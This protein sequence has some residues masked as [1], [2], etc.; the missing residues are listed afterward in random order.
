[1]NTNST[2]SKT[3]STETTTKTN[4]GYETPV[5]KVEET[6]DDF[7]YDIEKKVEEK[8]DETKKPEPEKKVEDEKAK[9]PSTGYS[10]V[11]ES[12]KNKDEK[13]PDEAKAPE[14]KSADEKLVE[15]LKESVKDLPEEIN[16][17]KV[18][19]FIQD[20]KMTKEQAKAYSELV[21]AEIAESKANREAF[22]KQQK[23]D[24]VKELKNDPEFGG[25]NF[26][27][28]VDRVEKV[29]ENNMP[30]LKKHLTERSGMLPPYIMKD[31]LA[32]SKALNPV[33]DFVK[34]DAGEVTESGNN[35][36]DDLYK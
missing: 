29:L 30:N 32:I 24:F 4:T 1:M 12:D 19:K 25:E 35:F 16:K 3:D 31:L 13:K 5:E 6:V 34:G 14:E 17:D 20:N 27:R 18:L 7:G 28:N 9:N 2:G 15:E 21:K 23:A 8:T 36:L 33:T 22:L 11:E 26:V 10:D